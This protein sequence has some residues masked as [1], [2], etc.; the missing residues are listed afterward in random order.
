[1]FRGVDEDYPGSC[2]GGPLAAARRWL[3]CFTVNRK[4]R[5]TANTVRA[6]ACT[7]MNS[8]RSLPS[9]PPPQSSPPPL[10]QSRRT[11]Y[12]SPSLALLLLEPPLAA[13]PAVCRVKDLIREPVSIGEKRA[14]RRL[15]DEG[16][17]YMCTR[18][19]PRIDSITIRDNSFKPRALLYFTHANGVMNFT[20]D[21][22][23]P[24]FPARVRAKWLSKCRLGEW[25]CARERRRLRKL[26]HCYEHQHRTVGKLM[27]QMEN[28]RA[29]SD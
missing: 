23:A 5:R 3:N 27:L 15:R 29:L 2:G 9:P 28:T 19:T 14:R 24:G 13:S 17:L 8:T 25:T 18:Q 20:W 16:P 12:R 4:L 22:S 26:A 10:P 7:P 11:Y 1:M 6:R 21:I